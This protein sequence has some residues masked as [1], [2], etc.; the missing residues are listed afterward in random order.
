MKKKEEPRGIACTNN[1]C[2]KR[3]TDETNTPGSCSYHPG[4]P[5]FHEGLK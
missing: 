4:N 1:G 2:N 5:V 3:F